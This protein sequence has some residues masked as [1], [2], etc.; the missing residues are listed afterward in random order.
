MEIPLRATVVFFFLWGL[1]RALGKRELAQM[2]AFEL[3]LLI[4]LGDLVQQGVT[5]EDYSVTGA[6][7]ATGTLAMWVLV[8]AYVSF[9]FQRARNVIEGDPVLIVRNGEPLVE[10]LRV[11]RLTV[12]EVLEEARQQGIGDLARVEVAL[13][14]PDGAFSFITFD[15]DRH[16][17]NEKKT[18]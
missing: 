14:E 12:D 5:Q 6:M 2:S 7:L 15:R 16:P 18:S 3:V 11:E 9:R 13:L 10:A 17:P 1:T 4:T 8:F